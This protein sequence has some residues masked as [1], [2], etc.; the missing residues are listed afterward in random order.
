[1]EQC[2]YLEG[3]ID[4][5]DLVTWNVI[6]IHKLSYARILNANFGMAGPNAKLADFTFR[7]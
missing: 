7:N 5:L 6:F 2:C 4:I 1:M 3:N